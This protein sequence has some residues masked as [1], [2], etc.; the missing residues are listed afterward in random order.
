MAEGAPERKLQEA[1]IISPGVV[2][3]HCWYIVG[4]FIYFMYF[5]K[6]ARYSQTPVMIVQRHEGPV[7]SLVKRVTG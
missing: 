7:K 1:L 3:R 6:V 5:E 2:H 4:L